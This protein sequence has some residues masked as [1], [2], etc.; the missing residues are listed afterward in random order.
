M[1]GYHAYLRVLERDPAGALKEAEKASTDST[2]DVLTAPVRAA[3]C[4]LA[5]DGAGARLAGKEARGPL[6]GKLLQR[7]DDIAAIS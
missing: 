6:E 1:I 2:A 4:V 5:G 3:I 7:P